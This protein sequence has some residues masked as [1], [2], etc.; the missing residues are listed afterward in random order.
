LAAGEALSAE[1][2]MGSP[3]DPEQPSVR[4][5][6]SIRRRARLGLPGNRIPFYWRTVGI[7]SLRY[8]SILVQPIR[9]CQAARER[10]RG[11][12]TRGM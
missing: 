4:A 3:E 8:S 7:P 11:S 12:A 5:S 10:R 1:D 6:T 2:P 9:A